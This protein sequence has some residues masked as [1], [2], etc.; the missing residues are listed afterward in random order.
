MQH[1]H[2]LLEFA[3]ILSDCNSDRGLSIVT[4]QGGK[5]IGDVSSVAVQIDGKDGRAGP[6]KVGSYTYNGPASDSSKS[7]VVITATFKD[8]SKQV[9]VDTNV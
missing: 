3:G 2:E 5:D 7:K 8:G 4:C 9:I 6:T 1:P